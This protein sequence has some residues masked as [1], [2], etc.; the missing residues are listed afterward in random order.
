MLRGGWSTAFRFP[1]FNELYQQSWFVGAD[2]G[3]FAF[4]IQV[5]VPNPGLEPEEIRTFELGLEY[6]FTPELSAKLDLFHSE[7]KD[8]IVMVGTGG[9]PIR[10][11]FENHRGKPPPW[12]QSSSCAS[13]R[14]RASSAR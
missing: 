7:V 8:F 4:P 2:L 14:R 9:G 5:M 13:G 10:V 3:A 1:A 6:R 11:G 12:G